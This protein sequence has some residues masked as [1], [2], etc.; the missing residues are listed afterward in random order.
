[1]RKTLLDLIENTII[2]QYDLPNSTAGISKTIFS[3]DDDKCFKTTNNND[4]SEIIYNSI[5]EYSFNEFEIDGKDYDKLHYIALQTKLKYNP[6]A[7][8]K[9]KIKYGFLGEVILFSVLYTLFK[10]KPLIARG[11][12]Y[13]PLENSE[14]KGYDSY[15]LI[16]NAG[17]TELWFGEVKFHN[18]YKAG[19]KSVFKNI[20]K[21]ISDNYLQT[22]VF[23]ISNELNNLQWKGSKIE[24]V[25]E[26]WKENPH[27]SIIDEIKKHNMKL[28]YPVMLLYEE[29]GAGYDESIKNIPTHIQV[30]YS[31]T[32][33]S[34]SIPYSIFFILIPMKDVKL[35]KEDVIKWIESKK[36][37]MS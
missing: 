11:Y 21:A 1:M 30:E 34:L 27:L 13:N 22:N 26:N 10:S 2:H 25:I 4:F 23:S 8:L 9:T 24:T 6:T 36:P 5:I 12:F 15:H 20:D 14:T 31:S 3:I 33:Y 16:E 37:L 29:D 18:N 19:I 17:Q 7:D 32:K 35:I 28:V